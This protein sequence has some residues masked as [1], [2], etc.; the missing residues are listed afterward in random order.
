MVSYLDA[1]GDVIASTSFEDSV[2]NLD[3]LLTYDPG[4]EF[5]VY[6]TTDYYGYFGDNTVEVEDQEGNLL[7][8]HTPMYD[9]DAYAADYYRDIA[10]CGGGMYDVAE[11]CWGYSPGHAGTVTGWSGD[12]FNITAHDINLLDDYYGDGT[13]GFDVFVVADDTYLVCHI[14]LAMNTSSDNCVVNVDDFMDQGDATEDMAVNAPQGVTWHL[15]NGL[16]ATTMIDTSDYWQQGLDDDI[17]GDGVL[18]DD[19]A[20]PM[21]ADETHDYDGDGVGDNADN[22]DDNDG[23][24]D[25]FDAFP[26]H[27]FAWDDT[28]DDGMPDMIS[29]TTGV[30]SD[31]FESG[32][33]SG[34]D[35]YAANGWELSGDVNCAVSS[36]N[37]VECTGLADSEEASIG[38]S[39]YTMEGWLTFDYW[40]ESEERYDQGCFYLDG[41]LIDGDGDGIGD[42]CDSGMAPDES[43]SQVDGDEFECGTAGSY[44]DEWIPLTW[45]ND[46]YDDCGDTDSDGVSDDEGATGVWT[47]KTNT[48]G[49]YVFEGNHT[50]TWTFSKDGS[51][52]AGGDYVHLDNVVIP[53]WVLGEGECEGTDDCNTE[54]LDDDGDGLE[55]L[56]DPCSLDGEETVDT[57]GDGFCDNQDADDDDDGVYDYNDAMPLDPT[58]QYDADG[59]GIG[60]NADPDDDN[61]GCDDVDDDMP[62][63]DSDCV[64]TDG[65]GVGND[66][67]QD[68]D[69]D[70][71]MDVD[72]P[73]PLDGD[74]WADN[75]G[76][77]IPDYTGDPPFLGNFEGG[78]IPAG[79]ITYGDANWFACGVSPSCT[80]TARAPIGGNWMGESGN[81]DNSQTSSV[82]FSMNTLA[83]SYSFAYETSTEG[84][85]DYL[86][87]YLDGMLTMSW[88]GQTSG[89]YSGTV[90]AGYHTF[91]WMYYK[92]GSVSTYD[93]TVWIDDVTL[94]ITQ[95]VYQGDTDDDNDGVLDDYDLYP[96]DPCV[97]MDTDG[98][99]APDWAYYGLFDMSMGVDPDNY[100]VDCD[101][102][103][104]MEDW[105]DDG[106]GWADEMEWVCGSDDLDGD[107]MPE[108]IDF[109]QVCDVLDDDLDNDGAPN[110]VD[111]VIYLWNDDLF[112]YV[113]CLVDNFNAADFNDDGE[114]DFWEL[115]AINSA[116]PSEDDDEDEGG[117]DHTFFCGD[118]SEILFEQVNDGT[119]DCPLGADEQQ[120]DED[121]NKTN[122]FDC[123][124]NST[125][126]IDQV[127]DGMD[128]CPN[129]E[130]EAS[131]Y[132]DTD[133][134]DT[135]GPSQE[136]IDEFTNETWNWVI[137]WDADNSTTISFDE[138]WELNNDS[139]AIPPG[140]ENPGWPG[141]DTEWDVF[142][143]DDS[144]WADNDGDGI[145]DNSDND[146]DNDGV[147]DS[148]DLF[149]LDGTEWED[150]DGDGIGD[151]SDNDTDGDGVPNDLDQFD[152]DP[153]ANADNDGDGADDASD[154]DDD[155]DGVPDVSDW[156]PMDPN[157]QY[158]SDGD[159]IGDNADTDDDGDGIP[160]ELDDFQYDAG[161]GADNDGDGVGDNADPD[162]DNDGV[163][164]GLDA[165]P[166]D[167]SESRD[168]DGD[169]LGDNADTDDDGDGVDDA[170]DAF[171]LNPA[172]HTDSD[173]DNIGDNS[174]G[175]I[176]GDDVPN[177]DDPFPNDP[178]EWADTDSDGTGDN[179]DTDDDNDG[180]SDSVE[181]DCGTDSKRPNSVP[182][183]FDGDGECDALDTTDSRSDEM[184]AENAQVDP[185]FTPGFPSILAAV[186]LIGAAMLGRRKED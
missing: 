91:Q 73:F 145:G 6:F 154:A 133:D 50:L 8:S 18:N 156:A 135:G 115:F 86:R 12:S 182:S 139:G 132:S 80:G 185:G 27:E 175:D 127:N 79:W 3:G 90:T 148:L 128:D 87:F 32:N 82:E 159:G 34:M 67:D 140:V 177:A 75:D 92:D 72:D 123:S 168:S 99:G 66:I 59:D 28:D 116:A 45:V 10:D 48:V 166:M 5:D 42:S 134:M 98:D 95:N 58:E 74:A 62:Y 63:D 85:W 52:S 183:D 153:D 89:T 24:N 146:D 106:D 105:D 31:D 121:G 161:E 81:I 173:G 19:D 88:S 111:C 35:D 33:L 38:V 126:W 55:D 143:F 26:L 65:D 14:R 54:D 84:Y 109:D 41:A 165:F 20:F 150:L 9:Y 53:Y 176:D 137:L 152:S 57:D 136:E 96:L 141:E 78:S 164:D 100:T 108:D 114:V 93:D 104:G 46:G 1:D 69:G 125:I 43:H 178:S 107:D 157:E 15:H 47:A 39:L 122:W 162:D 56:L 70:N 147:P 21:D 97:S 16:G 23:V 40:I 49:I 129:G 149:P 130:D 11:G 29:W 61:D 119:V 94:P 64:D 118:G 184:K 37:L 25:Y 142:P 68:D 13:G 180:Y 101:L 112:S 117:M 7:L 60:D 36:A 4:V 120:Y 22:D 124:D 160:D 77:G 158:D 17:D 113:D 44:G 151:N 71:V 144:E 83:G 186:S 103:M 174:D 51:V 172:E 102:W 163:P 2:E 181:A 30:I 170:S 131:F 179:A 110:P 167:S 138:Y 76:D 171:P 155:N 169:T